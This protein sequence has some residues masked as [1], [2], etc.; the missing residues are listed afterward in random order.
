MFLAWLKLKKRNLGPILNANG[1]AI[2]STVL[3]NPIFGATLTSL[4]KYPKVISKNDPFAIKKK[5]P[6]PFI[7]LLL[8]VIAA[9]VLLALVNKGIITF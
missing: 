7:V 1:W 8:V 5:S 3:L 6:L 9:A 4:A 2:N